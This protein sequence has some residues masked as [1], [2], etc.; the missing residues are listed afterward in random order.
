VGGGAN[1]AGAAAGGS[2]APTGVTPSRSSQP[3]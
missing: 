2:A 3:R 1:P